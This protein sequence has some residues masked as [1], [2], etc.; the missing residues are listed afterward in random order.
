MASEEKFSF[1]Q[2]DPSLIGEIASLLDQKSYSL[3]M[4]TNKLI[5]IACTSPNRLR[6]ISLNGEDADIDYAAI[7]MSSF[8]S[9]EVL[10]LSLHEFSE[11]SWDEST[12]VGR[13]LKS[14][15][16]MIQPKCLERPAPHILINEFMTQQ[17]LKFDALHNLSLWG[18]NGETS[19]CTLAAFSWLLSKFAMI[20][21]LNLHSIFV[22]IPCNV[23]V[24]ELRGSLPNLR[25]LG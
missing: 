16:I 3:L 25:K 8:H 14:L 20:V 11:L 10:Q 22:D 19:L 5:F 2:F 24:I 7:N 23:D 15:N 18:R 13:H 4:R 1:D 12:I 9:I 6:K 21:D 17:H